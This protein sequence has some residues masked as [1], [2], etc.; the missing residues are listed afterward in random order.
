MTAWV[1]HPTL[2]LAAEAIAAYVLARGRVGD[3]ELAAPASSSRAH[4]R[5]DRKCPIVNLCYRLKQFQIRCFQSPLLPFF[6]GNGDL[7][8]SLLL[9][10]GPAQ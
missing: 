2:A 8:V 5:I 1:E 4:E 3:P 10:Y 7:G 9:R 6:T